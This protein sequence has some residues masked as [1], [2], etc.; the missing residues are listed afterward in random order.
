MSQI[1]IDA[2]DGGDRLLIGDAGGRQ[3]QTDLRP[4]FCNQLADLLGAQ[5]AE[6]VDEA[7]AGIK[8]RVAGQALLDPR[9]PDQNQADAIAIEQVAQLLQAGDLEPIGLIDKEQT[10]R[11]QRRAARHAA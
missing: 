3:R 8:L 11:G 7:D 5:G 1:A 6:R 4:V 10:D 2:N 9:H